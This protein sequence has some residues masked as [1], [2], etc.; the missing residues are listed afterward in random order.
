[1]KKVTLFTVLFSLNASLATASEYSGNISL[2]LGNK[3]VSSSDWDGDES[4]NSI[5][6]IANIKQSNWPVSIALD[7]FLSLSEDLSEDNDEVSTSE[8]HLGVRKS[9][10]IPSLNLSPYLGGGLAVSFASLNEE[11]DGD[12]E[13]DLD[14]SIGTWFGIGANY[15]LLDKVSIGADIRYA[16]AEYKLHNKDFDATGV[17]SAISIGYVW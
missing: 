2:S 9:W 7:A 6:I 4:L 16:D 14:R 1:M 10:H 12:D 15:E 5:G 11:I 8:Y 13:N 3:E 17:S